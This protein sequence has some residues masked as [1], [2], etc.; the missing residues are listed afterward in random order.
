MKIRP[1]R[2]ELL[3]ADGQKD[4]RDEA[5]SCFSAIQRKRI[6]IVR[7]NNEKDLIRNILKKNQGRF[8]SITLIYSRYK[9]GILFYAKH[10]GRNNKSSHYNSKQCTILH[11]LRYCSGEFSENTFLWHHVIRS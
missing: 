10:N 7:K 9:N 6:K 1:V 4:G 2:T 5:N 11:N 8:L 3:R